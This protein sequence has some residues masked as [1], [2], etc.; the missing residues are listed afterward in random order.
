MIALIAINLPHQI[1]GIIGTLHSTTQRIVAIHEGRS[2][3][4][5]CRKSIR[6]DLIPYTSSYMNAF[7]SRYPPNTGTVRAENT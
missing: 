3:I 7:V 2:G 5:I 1:V 6:T 4:S